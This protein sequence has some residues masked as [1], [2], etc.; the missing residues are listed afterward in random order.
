MI[1]FPFWPDVYQPLFWLWW[2]QTGLRRVRDTIFQHKNG[3]R[4]EAPNFV[5]LISDGETNSQVELEREAQLLKKD[6]RATIVVISTGEKGDVSL[7][8]VASNE[9]DI[10]IAKWNDGN[11]QEALQAR[12]VRTDHVATLAEYVRILNF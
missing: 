8:K 9:D 1:S 3:D 4:P 11:G 7:N 2:L 12:Q 6:S 5:I 10:I